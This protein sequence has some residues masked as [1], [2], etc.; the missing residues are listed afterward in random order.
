MTLNIVFSVATSI[1]SNLG[2]PTNLFHPVIFLTFNVNAGIFYG[3]LS[4]LQ[5]IVMDLNNDMTNT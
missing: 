5:N 1:L 3:I 2:P 4:I